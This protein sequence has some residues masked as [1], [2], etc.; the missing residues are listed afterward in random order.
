MLEIIIN[1]N[2]IQVPEGS[3][4]L[5]AAQ[6]LK[7]DI[8]TLCFLKRYK[9]FTS[10]MIC[11]VAEKKT[12]KLLPSCSTLVADGM[13]IETD[14]SEV[15]S[16]RRDALELL[17]SEHLG[18]CEAPC[19]RICP[20]HLNIP[21]MLRQI[22]ANDLKAAIRTIKE[23][24]ALPAVLGRICPA[25]C[26]NGCRRKEFDQPVSIC[27]QKRFAADI[28]LASE[29]PFLPEIAPASGQKIAIVGAGPTGL[30]A[31]YYLQQLGHACTLFE[32][33]SEPGGALHYAVPIDNLPR[34]VLQAEINI[35]KKLGAQ[36]QSGIE[37]G[38]KI[39][40]DELQ[41]KFD[42]IIL[43]TGQLPPEKFKEFGLELTPNGF[44]VNK[45]TFETSQPG[46]FAGGNAIRK[47]KMTVTSVGHGHAIAISVNQFLTNQPVIGPRDRFNS[48]LGRLH[49]EE[50]SEFIKN[51]DQTHRHEPSNGMNHGFTPDEATAEAER[52]L[53]CDCRKP[54]SCKLRKYA[55]FYQANQQRFKSTSRK[56]FEKQIQHPEVIYEPGKCI[57][58]GIC[59]QITEKSSEK[60]GL[61][62][63]GRGFNVKI[64]VPLNETLEKGLQEVAAEC[65]RN[66]PTAALSF[67]SGED[68]CK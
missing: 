63:T 49:D 13:E 35:I 24:I 52:C 14:S 50:I 8:P 31:A 5:A 39:N 6:K 61:T 64:G 44:K 25:P 53:H 55:D 34:E 60:L 26:E 4:I 46:I 11:L 68:K 9:P 1:Q 23:T 42:A 30:A 20:A 29:N 10:C 47:G 45:T 54:E 33:N 17:L 16:A 28:D 62:F 38:Q 36:F 18:D 67:N 15:Y 37:I 32:K 7:I 21:L 66:C 2:K 51:V 43:A 65:V 41:K 19:Q 27:L 22:A 56:K 59:V 40:L 12:E 58:C 57:K 48:I 3:T